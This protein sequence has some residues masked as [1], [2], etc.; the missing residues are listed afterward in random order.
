MNTPETKLASVTSGKATLTN[1]RS[2]RGCRVQPTVFIRRLKCSFSRIRYQALP[3]ST[4]PPRTVN[5]R[6]TQPTAY[7]RAK[8]DEISHPICGQD[9]AQT[10]HT[11]TRTHVLQ[12]Y[13]SLRIA[14][15]ISVRQYSTSRRA[16]QRKKN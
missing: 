13:T 4:S 15:K 9:G 5:T 12:L 10:T 2:R 1:E 11:L 7:S 6:R 3:K 8:K 14:G 16:R